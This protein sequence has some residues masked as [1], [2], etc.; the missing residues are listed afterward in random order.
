MKKILVAL[1]FLSIVGHGQTAKVI[2]L[3]PDDAKQAKAL[4]DEQIALDKR[5]A[6]F[7][8][9]VRTR[10]LTVKK[11]DKEWGDEGV[12]F[13]IN[14]AGV[15]VKTSYRAG[16]N[17]GQFEYS[18]DFKYIVPKSMLIN[19]TGSLQFWNNGCNYINPVTTTAPYAI[20]GQ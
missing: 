16:W 9:L 19:G 4:Y 14:G 8:E 11:G 17:Y 13:S 18:E 20:T 6:A 10:Y 5:K 2:Q 7:E 3:S 1:V 15:T 12:V